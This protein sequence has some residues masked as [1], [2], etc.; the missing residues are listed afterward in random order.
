MSS[1][2]LPYTPRTPSSSEHQ[3]LLD[4][5]A[6]KVHFGSNEPGS[7]SPEVAQSKDVFHFG[8]PEDLEAYPPGITQDDSSDT[9][10]EAQ[11][12]QMQ[13]EEHDQPI[14]VTLNSDEVSINLA[15]TEQQRLP[16]N[17]FTTQGTTT[18][19][20]SDHAEGSATVEKSQMG[21]GQEGA[22][23]VAELEKQLAE[24]RQARSADNQAFSDLK[25][26]VTRKFRQ[27]ETQ[28]NGEKAAWT[29][30]GSQFARE[31]E[32]W[33]KM[34]A[35]AEAIYSTMEKRVLAEK[36]ELQQA[37]VK[38]NE[39]AEAASNALETMRQE[40]DKQN[41]IMALLPPR[42]DW[43]NPQQQAPAGH[44]WALGWKA[45]RLP[46]PSSDGMQISHPASL[47]MP[48]VGVGMHLTGMQLP[49]SEQTQLPDSDPAYEP[50]G[51]SDN[52]VLEP[53][54]DEAPRQDKGKG[55]AS[56]ESPEQ[57]RPRKLR[58]LQKVADAMQE[59][60]EAL[61]VLETM[62]SGNLAN[63]EAG[64]FEDDEDSSEE[65]DSD[66]A[67][68]PQIELP[69]ASESSPSVTRIIRS[70]AGPGP[71]NTTQGQTV[72]GYEAAR[73]PL[74]SVPG[75]PVKERPLPPGLSY[76][77]IIDSYPNHLRG[78]VLLDL[79]NNSGYTCAE[80]SHR[81]ALQNGNNLSANTLWRRVEREMR[82]T[83]LYPELEKVNIIEPRKA[84]RRT[85]RIYDH[86]TIPLQILPRNSALRG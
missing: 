60:D 1:H 43:P 28:F 59:E 62:D 79:F 13:G 31:Q 82:E 47:V 2:Q 6:S 38:A 81:V 45:S 40:Y 24:E 32:S 35:G 55:R 3:K 4:E 19:S 11:T 75:F 48:S 8:D 33:E 46:S 27:T 23:R 57:A 80:I 50:A 49:H 78:S 65:Y 77:Q 39:R 56:R 72:L 10:A 51:Q 44:Y 69:P 34:K 16:G 86:L 54:E 58:K 22:E 73:V 71:S 30:R 29:Q 61:F 70:A 5:I 25:R 37:A 83:G 68:P 36:A 17:E 42:A 76:E 52:E 84:I 53:S 9:S 26:R 66:D 21:K 20:G 64:D 74:G 85:R 41:K 15:N 63:E 67:M 14:N 12:V 7:E 18:S